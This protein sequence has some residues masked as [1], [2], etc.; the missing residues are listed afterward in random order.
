MYIHKLRQSTAGLGNR[1]S[2]VGKGGALKMYHKRTSGSGIVPEIYS[3][4]KIQKATEVL[5]NLKISK[6]RMPKKYI[7]FE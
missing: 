4:G 6:S 5:K 1:V 7:S 3:D 2:I